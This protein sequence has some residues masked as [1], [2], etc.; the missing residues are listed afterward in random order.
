MAP[1]VSPSPKT[2]GRN[3]KA[4]SSEKTDGTLV[5][6]DESWRN[7]GRVFRSKILTDD[8]V[9]GNMFALSD[10]CA[11]ERYYRVA[12]RYEYYRSTSVC[13]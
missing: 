9:G 11:I 10:S 12:D 5:E 2:K 6:D 13:D 1:I 8:E 3:L 7:H 4:G